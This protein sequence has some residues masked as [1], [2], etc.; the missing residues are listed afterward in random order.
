MDQGPLKS[1]NFWISYDFWGP[2]QKIP[3][4]IYEQHFFLKVKTWSLNSD[5]SYYNT[6]KNKLL[7]VKVRW[8]NRKC[9]NG[10]KNMLL[11]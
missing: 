5:K 10:L 2:S 8:L 11:I 1:G 3:A 6:P 7:T 4:Q 9:Q